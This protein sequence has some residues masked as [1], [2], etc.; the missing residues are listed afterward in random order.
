MLY[1]KQERY[2]TEDGTRYLSDISVFPCNCEICSKYTPDELR[3]L[4]GQDKINEIA[5]HNLHAIKLEV[6]KVKQAIY[7]GRLWEYVLKKARAHPK[8]FEMVEILINN[9]ESLSISTPKFKEKAIFLY[10]KYDQYRPE[11]MSYHTIVRKFKSKKKSL[12]LLKE[13]QT[14][15]GYLSHD[16][17]AL[18][19]KYKEIDS[20]EICYYNPQLGLI[21]NEI[22]DI[23]PAA[24]HETARLNF[25]P[26]EFTEFEKTWIK[27]F[28]NNKFSEIYFDKGD[29]F[30]A[31]FIKL[32]PKGISKKSLK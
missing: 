28:K 8:L 16:Y 29:N 1:A 30:V 21:P 10:D 26:K 17:F 7:E 22:S 11:V 19:R 23:F 24:H 25:D 12:I 14:K 3:Q 6:D 9:S 20:F 32:L 15:P 13:P 5:I 18:K 27:F 31:N 2:I 4:K